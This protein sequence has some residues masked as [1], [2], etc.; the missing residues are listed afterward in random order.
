MSATT[1]KKNRA[2]MSKLQMEAL[3]PPKETKIEEPTVVATI[4]AAPINNEDDSLDIS[5]PSDM[6]EELC[7]IPK[8]VLVSHEEY[9]TTTPVE[10]FKTFT[11]NV[12]GMIDRYEKNKERL[13]ELED[14]MQDVLHFAE[15]AEDKNGPNG[16]KLYK[17][18]RDIRRER[19]QCKNEIDLLQP[20]YD[21]FHATTMLDR[22]SAIQ[23][24]C[25]RIKRSIE[26]KGYSV[27][28]D[29]L[30]DVL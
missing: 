18:I 22:L 6:P 5:L 15:M 28:T 2:R 30:E 13:I 21:M 20:V 25:G 12:R 10:V 4:D 1:R 9:D 16:F 8:P 29:I 23:G 17:H 11:R 19:R 26:A 24:E 3:M 7:V 14:S 27:R